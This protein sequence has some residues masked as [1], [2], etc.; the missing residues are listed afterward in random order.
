MAMLSGVEG[1]AAY[2]GLEGSPELVRRAHRRM[3]AWSEGRTKGHL[4]IRVEEGPFADVLP[5]V[6]REGWKWDLVY[7]DGHHSGE[8]LLSQWEDVIPHVAPGGV[9]VIDDIRW[10]KGMHAAWNQIVQQGGGDGLD[11][12]RLGLV[13]MPG[14]GGHKSG[15]GLAF[16]APIALWA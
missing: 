4:E 7:L 11:A 15:A 16:R 9:V 10:S 14:A 6:L 3:A 8:V 2:V 13:V 1:D 12:F 5:R